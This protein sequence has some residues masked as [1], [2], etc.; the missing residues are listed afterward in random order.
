MF[1]V[2]Q[3]YSIIIEININELKNLKMNGKQ[4]EYQKRQDHW[5]KV[6][7]NDYAIS[8][9]EVDAYFPELLNI[10]SNKYTKVLEIGSGY[11]RVIKALSQK[12][13]K[14]EQTFIGL[15]KYLIPD[16]EDQYF[17]VVGDA[18]KVPF[19][20]DCFDL[21]YSLGVVEHF[22]ETEQAI[23]EH[24]RV[25]KKGG[26]VL[27]TVP[28]LSFSTPFRYVNYFRRYRRKGSFEQTLGRNHTVRYIENMLKKKGVCIKYSGAF[29]FY[30]PGV[31]QALRCRLEK[32]LPKVIF[33]SYVVV[34]AIKV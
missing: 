9:W 30:L 6:L 14:L 22:P 26:V 21:V 16:N 10:C 27:V 33:G 24:V 8:P 12:S 3:D 34:V 2:Y 19:K 32:F 20:D 11:G 4:D 18:L 23:F 31:P 29:G 25:L 5:E 17:A 7:H 1:F 13:E 15:D 28:R